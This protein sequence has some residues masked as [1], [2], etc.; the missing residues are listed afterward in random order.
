MLYHQGTVYL[1]SENVFLRPFVQE[2]AGAMYKN[3]A[4][5]ER[6]VEYLIWNVYTIQ[7]EAEKTV[8]QWVA[9]YDEETMYHWA[10]ITK[11]G[12]EPIGSISLVNKNDYFQSGEVGYC[13]GSK[14]WGQGYATEALTLVI[15]YLMGE[16]G[17]HRLEGKHEIG[18]VGSGKVMLKA[19]MLREGILKGAYKRKDGSFCDVVLNGITR[20][21]WEVL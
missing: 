6:T 15:N 18:N 11:E 14:W 2:D 1:E 3:W 16:V 5:D 9:N 13:L 10:I 7:E 19:G 17:F 8:R 21:R 12:D 4:S 20:E